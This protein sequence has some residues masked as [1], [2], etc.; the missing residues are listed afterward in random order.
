MRSADPN[1]NPSPNPNPNPNPNPDPNPN[2]NP[3]Q[4]SALLTLVSVYVV[5]FAMPESMRSMTAAQ[6]R[7]S[8]GETFAKA[9]GA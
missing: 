4:V 3:N 7:S 5:F 1:P 8:V 9:R 2:P 6:E